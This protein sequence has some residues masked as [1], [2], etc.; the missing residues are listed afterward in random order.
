MSIF[1]LSSVL[2]ITL[3]GFV[4]ILFS[5]LLYVIFKQYKLRISSEEKML[6]KKTF[7]RSLALLEEARQRSIEIINESS[8]KSQ[9]ILHDS[10]LLTADARE[11]LKKQLKDASNKQV[12]KLDTVT[13]EMLRD[14]KDALEKEKD[15]SVNVI[16]GVSEDI[17]GEALNEIDEF[18]KVLHKETVDSEKAVEEK[19]NAEYEKVRAEVEAYKKEQ[20]QKIH[21]KINDLMADVVRELIGSELSVEQHEHLVMEALNKA[22]SKL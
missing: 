3:N 18:A 5:F 19:L 12:K 7:D 1:D 15:L 2:I 9:E 13:S 14:Y 22:K 8:A 20:I 21:S 11:F 4:I 17:K 6:K 16:K 10:D